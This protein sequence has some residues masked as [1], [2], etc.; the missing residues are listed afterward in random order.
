MVGNDAP[1]RVQITVSRLRVQNTET[2]QSVA[3]KT[4]ASLLM[5]SLHLRPH[6]PHIRAVT[7]PT[8]HAMVRRSASHKYNL[9]HDMIAETVNQANHCFSS[10]MNTS[11]KTQKRSSTMSR[12]SSCLKWQ[13]Q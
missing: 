2:P 5:P 1:S 11:T 13:M 8:P 7:P 3:L 4:T 10:L 9:S 6:T 12:S